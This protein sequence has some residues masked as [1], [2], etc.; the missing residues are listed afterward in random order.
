[1]AEDRGD[2]FSAIWTKAKL[3]YTEITGKEM[4]D[5]GFPHPS[6]TQELLSA[7]DHQN[8]DFAHFRKKR[9]IV[10]NILEMTCKPIELVGNLAAG[11]ASMAFPPSTLCFGAAVYLINA[12]RGVSSSL[13]A[14]LDLFARLKDFLIRLSVYNQE[15]LPAELREKLAETLATLLDIFARSTKVINAGSGGRVLQFAKNVLVVKD[16]T[17]EALVS[18]IDKMTESETRLVGAETLIQAK[19]SGRK[20]DGVAVAV[21]DTNMAVREGNLKLEVVSGGVEQMTADQKE[22]HKEIRQGI[23]ALSST[24]NETAARTEDS[25]YTRQKHHVKALLQPSVSAVDTMTAIAKKRVVGT[26]D[27]VRQEQKYQRWTAQESPILWISGNPGTG[28]SY[29]AENIVS[30]LWQRHPQG[31]HHPSRTSVG[32]FFFK[33]NDPQTRSFHQALRDIAHQV[34]QNDPFY[35]KHIS[36]ACQG[37]ED[38]KTLQSV[39]RVLF[40]KFFLENTKTDGHVYLVM[41]A[42]DEAFQEERKLFFELL[43]DLYSAQKSTGSASR[44]HLVMLGRPQIL[45]EITETLED[46]IPTIYVDWR[47]NNADIIRYLEY[48]IKKSRA[49]SQA[50]EDLQ[51]E[52]I[53]TLTEKANGMFMW[54]DLMLRELSSKSR[55]S[56]IRDALNRAPKGLNEMLRHIF[57]GFSMTLKDDDPEDLNTMLSWVACAQ[58]PLSLQQ[59]DGLLALRSAS[60]DSILS[61]ESRLRTQ[62][63]SLFVITR[64]DGLSTADLFGDDVM[65]NTIDI[66]Q[67]MELRPAFQTTHVTFCHASV[68]DFLRDENQ[69]KVSAQDGHPAVGVDIIQARASTLKTCLEAE[70]EMSSE[71]AHHAIWLYARFEWHRH[72]VLAAKHLPE[73]KVREKQEIGKLLVQLLRDEEIVWWWIGNPAGFY[74]EENLKPIR[75]WLE[76]R[77]VLDSQDDVDR[78]WIQ[79]TAENPAETY[80]MALRINCK[81]WLQGVYYEPM[82]TMKAACD[83][84]CLQS[85]QAMIPPGKQIPLERILSTA[86]YLQLQETEKWHHRLGTALFDCGYVHEAKKH[87][88]AAI[89]LDYTSWEARAGIARVLEKEKRYEEAIELEKINITI[90]EKNLAGLRASN[91]DDLI[92]KTECALWICL[93]K[94]CSWYLVLKD[95]KSSLE[96]L[97]EISRFRFVSFDLFPSQI[98][99][100]KEAE[101]YEVIVKL[102]KDME[103]K[104]SG[105]GLIELTQCL[106][107]LKWPD[108]QFFKDIAIAASHTG[109]IAWLQTAYQNAIGSARNWQ[110]IALTVILEVCLAELYYKYDDKQALALPLWERIVDIGSAVGKTGSWQLNR[111]YGIVQRSFFVYCLEQALDPE[112]GTQEASSYVAKLEKLCKLKSADGIPSKDIILANFAAVFVGLLYRLKGRKEEAKDYFRPVIKESLM[113]LSD[114]DSDRNQSGFA[115]LARVLVAAGDE[116]HAIAIYNELRAER[117]DKED[118][119]KSQGAPVKDKEANATSDEGSRQEVIKFEVSNTDKSGNT[120]HPSSQAMQSVRRNV[121]LARQVFPQGTYFYPLQCDGPCRQSFPFFSGMFMCRICLCDLCPECVTLVRSSGPGDVN[122]SR[123]W[124]NGRVCSPH[125]DWLYIT[126]PPEKVSQTEDVKTLKEGDDGQEPVLDNQKGVCEEEVAEMKRILARLKETWLD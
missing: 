87:F 4:D 26:G 97:E 80:A 22:F 68:G 118:E 36:M 108:E 72:L 24:L 94:L 93:R 117:L 109:Q 31:V 85:G 32:Y 123:Y 90:L 44:I 5:P 122:D 54:V 95:T 42:I 10:F 62:F 29:L 116:V 9:A 18:K 89:E 49:L 21:S 102:L 88:E 46:A 112:V 48:S 20:I 77:D 73:M 12:A 76:D 75:Q 51:A 60:G 74:N 59:L 124:D 79:S 16:E 15:C 7:L 27:W 47:K 105:R 104:A 50:P 96:C 35:E 81:I 82:E 67:E 86:R 92:E 28:K 52:V 121:T 38:I 17:I 111:C 100:F 34:S 3:Q 83:I 114:G 8:K 45:D 43:S 6:S 55:V 78:E 56:A 39:W 110:D 13:D 61:L 65:K 30:H 98:S 63:A 19:R 1:M 2:Q 11:G 14:I 66:K 115:D 91:Q 71:Y 126:P 107:A 106:F 57:E 33:D 84:I 103:R 64:E 120:A 25:Q 125:H 70:R 58:R 113:V 99:M 23:D 69:G 101:D 40:L 119:G 53:K 37:P 41:D